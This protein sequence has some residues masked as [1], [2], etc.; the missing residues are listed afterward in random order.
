[1]TASR[2]PHTPE[3]WSAASRGY[4]KIAPRLMEPFAHEMVER[5]ALDGTQSVL[6]VAAG[7]GALTFALAEHAGSV[8]A[9]DFAPKMLEVLQERLD[10]GGPT[11]VRL[12]RMDGLA[13]SVEDG[14][15]DRAACS[16][17]LMLF[18]DRAQG[19]R[20]LRRAV[21]SG[22]RV[23]VSGWAGPDRFDL[24]ALFLDALNRA[25]PDRPAPPAP[26]PVFSLG[27]PTQFAAELSA[28]GFVEVQVDYVTRHMVLQGFDEVWSMLTA[29]A[30]PVQVML[31]RIGEAGR[32][33]LEDAV[34]ALIDERWAKGPIRLANTAT[35]G[36]GVAD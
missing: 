6:E 18:P 34:R 10:A 3:N 23:A 1:M 14:C 16:F 2:N 12:Q 36:S 31:D 19:F 20:E 24:F 13:L 8:L 28:A 5:L 11:N 26:P 32:G 9:T 33:V 15:F 29:G 17:A 30:P 35:V 21:R 27:D 7:T 25:F 22:G 4:T